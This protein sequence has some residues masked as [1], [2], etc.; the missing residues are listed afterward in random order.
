MTSLSESIYG[1][2]YGPA[3]KKADN[4]KDI[5][6]CDVTDDRI[7]HWL[8]DNIQEDHFSQM[9]QFGVQLLR[10][11]TGYWNWIT[12]PEG[13]TPNAP[14]DV[15][16]RYKNLQAV[17]KEQYQPYIDKIISYCQKYNI[18]F[19]FEMHGA[20]G[21]QNGEMH[22]GCITGW[23]DIGK[24]NH[25][26]DTDWNK[27]IAVET[28]GVMA[29]KCAEYPD[30]CYG[31]GVLNEPQPGLTSPLP[32]TLHS[33]LDGYFGEAIL[34]ARKYLD[35]DVPVVLYS[36]WYE[37]VLWSETHYPYDTYGKVVWDTHIYTKDKS[38]VDSALK[39]YDKFLKM[40]QSFQD[41]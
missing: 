3:V 9:Q 12:L 13:T 7:L 6:F 16:A 19:F 21:S 40:V 10:I 30:L 18:K 32:W 39:S 34:E 23:A 33:F 35:K 5:S 37:F 38:S 28:V 8:D 36:W 20:P 24:P 15:A 14:D 29:Q 41:K 26:F 17:T 22:S 1:S 27:Q 11:P 31:V 4:V 25:Y 2:K